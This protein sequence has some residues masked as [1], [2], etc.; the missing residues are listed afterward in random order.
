MMTLEPPSWR[1]TSGNPATVRMFGE[2]NEEEFCC[3]RA[4]GTV[5]RSQPDGR[6]S[7]EKQR[8]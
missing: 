8:R 6:A 2:T 4:M 7:S 5:P 3:S 1:F